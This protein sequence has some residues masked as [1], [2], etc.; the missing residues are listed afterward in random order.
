MATT[1]IPLLIIYNTHNHI[2]TNPDC[3]NDVEIL[4]KTAITTLGCPLS[5]LTIVYYY[6]SLQ[7]DRGNFKQTKLLTPTIAIPVFSGRHRSLYV[8]CSDHVVQDGTCELQCVY[9]DKGKENGNCYI[10]GAI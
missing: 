2:S 8:L 6:G 3:T 4:M 5:M 7:Y 10:M 9:R 1:V